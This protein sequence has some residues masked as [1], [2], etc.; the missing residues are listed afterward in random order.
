MSKVF[1]V[2]HGQTAWNVGEIFRGRMDI[3]LG[4]LDSSPPDVFNHNLETVPRLYKLARPGADSSVARRPS[5]QARCCSRPRSR[6][7]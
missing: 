3:A 2:R 1:L 4:I 7:R 5:R 6:C